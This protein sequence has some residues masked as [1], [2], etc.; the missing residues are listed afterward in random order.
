MLKTKNRNIS[1]L[2]VVVIVFAFMP[3]IAMPSY[4]DDPFEME[5]DSV[6][7]NSGTEDN[8]EWVFTTSGSAN[9]KNAVS[10]D[11]NIA[12]VEFTTGWIKVYPVSPGETT[13]TVTAVNDKTASVKVT[14]VEEY[15]VRQLKYRTYI[16]N[17]WYGTKKLH[18]M[19]DAGA[20]GSVKIDKNTYKFTADES[21]DADIKLKKVYKLNTKIKITV[22]SG[23]YTA[24][25]NNYKFWAAT[26]FDNVSASKHKVQ[27]E[28]FNLHKGDVVKVVYK[29]KTYKKKISKDYDNK[30]SK[31]TV[32][33]GKTLK[34]NSTLK[35]SIVNKDKKTLTST[36][37]KLS[38]WKYVQPD[39]DA[40]DEEYSE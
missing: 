5:T 18:I 33:I 6:S 37:F 40:P 36:K 29:G 20:T 22:T 27:M 30:T 7:F 9:I 17:C 16:E 23:A 26:T 39:P 1:I 8:S 31:V 38:D 28:C 4:A 24:S 11:A 25:V 2:L 19:T 12:T 34:K 35:V 21:G 32:K 15:F 14:V 3:L 10:A 13:I